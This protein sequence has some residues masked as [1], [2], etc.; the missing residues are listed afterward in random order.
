MTDFAPLALM[1]MALVA[2]LIGKALIAAAREHVRAMH[3]DWYAELSAQ[4]SRFRLGGAD[5]RARRR[6]A[7][8]LIFGPL[9]PGPAADPLLRDLARKT[10]LAMG[11]LALCSA[12][13]VAILWLRAAAG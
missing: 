6:L 1:T 9:P 11:A 2:A 10:K 7:R 4:G 12:G 8:P 5:D 13:V 3:P